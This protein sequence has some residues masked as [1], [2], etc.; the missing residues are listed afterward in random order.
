LG[1]F[2]H[3]PWTWAPR[4]EASRRHPAWR[5]SRVFSQNW[6]LNIDWASSRKKTRYAFWI[7]YTLFMF[8]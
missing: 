2:F 3:R 4:P 6:E 1:D 7:F 5:W 8:G